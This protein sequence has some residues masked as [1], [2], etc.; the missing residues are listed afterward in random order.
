MAFARLN[1]S[2]RAA[3]RIRRDPR[4][5]E[6]Y[7]SYGSRLLF[8]PG[9]PAWNC[10]LGRGSALSYRHIDTGSGDF[11]CRLSGLQQSGGAEPEWP[12]QYLNVGAAISQLDRESLHVPVGICR[13]RLHYYY[14]SLGRRWYC[15]LDSK[16]SCTTVAASS[17]GSDSAASRQAI[18][19]QGFKEAIGI[20]VFLVAIYLA[21]NLVVVSV[22]VVEVLK[23]PQVI[24]GWKQQLWHQH[25]SVW[26][27]L[28]VSVILFP[29][30][31]LGL[32][33]FETGW[34]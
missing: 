16:S 14:H 32:S 20:A 23:H 17:R 2:A 15:A 22:A 13:Y 7:V 28:A 9:I 8:Y 29:K 11:V 24:T 4:L 19:L 18:F 1:R 26:L 27:M 34:P 10:V 5:V 25:G 31:A 6:S 12:G 30:L 3:R 33:G 21:L